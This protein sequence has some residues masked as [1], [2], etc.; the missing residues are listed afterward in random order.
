VRFY[1]LAGGRC[2]VLRNGERRRTEFAGDLIQVLERF[3]LTG[4][5]ARPT[6]PESQIISTS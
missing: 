2:G 6:I 3:A 5:W 1:A 4:R